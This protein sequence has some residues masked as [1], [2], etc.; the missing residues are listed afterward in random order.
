[1]PSFDVVSE[2]DDVGIRH[3]ADNTV[4]ELAT[5]W[6]FRNVE[7]SVEYLKG[8]ITL[9]AEADFQCRQLLDMLRANLVKQGVDPGAIDDSGGL[10][11]SGKTFSLTVRFHQ[12]IA[13]EAGKKIVKLLK[14]NKCKVQ[15]AIQGDKV[16]VSGKKRDDLQAAIALIKQAELDQPLQFNNFRD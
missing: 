9:K 1:M 2:V 15:G 12:G 14:D 7:A 5:R 4:R 3:A 11:H 13:T 16:R 8:V 6:D 10:V